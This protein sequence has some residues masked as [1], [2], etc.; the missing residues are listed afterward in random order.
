MVAAEAP[1]EAYLSWQRRLARPHHSLWAEIRRGSYSGDY[2][3]VAGRSGARVSVKNIRCDTRENRELAL[4]KC[5]AQSS[6]RGATRTSCILK[7]ASRR[8]RSASRTWRSV[9]CNGLAQRMRPG[10][11]SSQLYVCVVE[12]SLRGARIL[13]YAEEPSCLWFVMKFC[14][15]GDLNRYLLSW[16]PDLATN[17]SFVLQLTSAIAFLHTNHIFVRDLSADNVNVL[18]M[19]GPGT[20]I[21]KVADF[22]L[23]K[24]ADQT[25]FTV[26]CEVWEGHSTAKADIFVQGII[27]GAVIERITKIVLL[28]KALLENRKMELHI[29][30]KL[31]ISMFEGIKQLLKDM[32][33]SNPQDHPNAFELATRMNRVTCAA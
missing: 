13:S 6:L 27:I 23:S 22:G 30:Q 11:R 32:L 25:Y 20:P 3:A 10:K 26:A 14:D 1:G 17:Q 18:V 8:R 16:R 28:G 12:T 21:L 33:A 15:G 9:L 24:R 2:E 29:P 7:S 5:G 4:A 19:E 31:S